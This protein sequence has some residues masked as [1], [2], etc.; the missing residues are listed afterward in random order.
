LKLADGQALTLLN[1]TYVDGRLCGTIVGG[2]RVAGDSGRQRAR[3]VGRRERS[4]ELAAAL[5]EPAG[6]DDIAYAARDKSVLAVR[7]VALGVE[8]GAMKFRF[9]RAERS[10]TL[11]RLVGVVYARSPATRRRPRRCR[12]STSPAATC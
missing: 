1:G 8:G 7:G 3:M 6:T 12:S 4:I 10:I 11:N 2:P 5:N 9:R